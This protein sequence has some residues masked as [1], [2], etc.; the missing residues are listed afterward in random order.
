[1]Q[2]TTVLPATSDK[3]APV[4]QKDAEPKAQVQPYRDSSTTETML[5]LQ[6][7]HGNRFVQR[8]IQAKLEVSHPGDPCEQEADQ[9]ADRIMS[10]PMEPAP[11]LAHRAV[12]PE[13]E[14]DKQESAQSVPVKRMATS[15]IQKPFEEEDKEKKPDQTIT[16]A[17]TAENESENGVLPRAEEA[18]S[19]ASSSTGQ[20]LPPNLHRKFEQGLGADL[21]A[22]RVHTG[23]QSVEANKAISARAYTTGND[24]HFNQSQYDPESAEGQRLLAHEVT[25]TVQQ[26]GGTLR[27]MKEREEKVASAL[28]HEPSAQGTGIA[29]IADQ[30]RE[31]PS[32]NIS[33]GTSNK[34]ISSSKDILSSF[35]IAFRS[36]GAIVWRDPKKTTQSAPSPASLEEKISAIFENQV[37]SD[38]ANQ[39][40]SRVLLCVMTFLDAVN[41]TIRKVG[42]D[43]KALKESPPLL[44]MITE[45]AL[46]ALIPGGAGLVL[47]PLKNII[48]GV[49]SA[50]LN[51]AIKSN[52][53][54]ETEAIKAYLE[55][56]KKIDELAQKVGD[57]SAKKL[58]SATT[59]QQKPG[60]SS[61]V[62]KQ[63]ANEDFLVG[64]KMQMQKSAQAITDSLGTRSLE[65]IT[66]IWAAY[67][68]SKNTQGM[69][70]GQIRERLASYKELKGGAGKNLWYLDIWGGHR[71]CVLTSTP[72]S[73]VAFQKE[74]FSF[75]RY[76][77]PEEQEMAIGAAGG[78][79]P[80]FDLAAH[81][82]GGKE[83]NLSVF[84]GH[85]PQPEVETSFIAE[86]NAWGGPHLAYV[87]VVAGVARFVRWV[88]P[89]QVE[90]E[91]KKGESQ[92]TGLR[93]YM[94]RELI[95]PIPRPIS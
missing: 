45:M 15:S 39:A 28:G 48:K 21:S 77:P 41:N 57:A 1:M 2:T 62:Y 49:A 71:L 31:Q 58:I 16:A 95:G 5:R 13:E 67:D 10:M 22:V 80:T 14:K 84:T 9:V 26:T 36:H 75:V 12:I 81:R 52:A 63:G 50:A 74:T 79:I 73:G 27:K 23:P 61:G 94:D 88:S 56:D 89:E 44:S 54:D 93:K 17:R 76:V 65:E 18:V 85:I 37:K 4:R 69:F 70:E 83:Y 29:S 35:P 64:L 32:S 11:P 46:G 33:S 30:R 40:R 66:A 6:R 92:P 60:L 59:T 82:P 43:E 87:A 78:V 38:I 72:L 42:D 47:G 34:A 20:P 19:A 24:I 68:V 7:T 55:V 53:I 51:K 3:A 86:V 90:W 25:H 8:I 91:R